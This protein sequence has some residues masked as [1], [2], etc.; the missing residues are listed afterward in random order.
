MLSTL[1]RPRWL[2]AALVVTAL[3]GLFIRLGLWQLERLDERRA[4][5]RVAVERLGSDPIDLFTALTEI[6]P[7]DLEYRRVTV[8]GRFAPEEEVLI[9]SQTHQGSAGFHIVSPLVDGSRG[10]LVNR[11]W[12]PLGMDRVPVTQA[13]PRAGEVTIEG[14]VHLTQTRPP[15]GPEEPPG[16]LEIFNRV[17]IDRIQ[18]QVT[19]E[20]GPVYVV[21]LGERGQGLPEPVE[22]PDFSQQG[23]H[24]AYAIQWFSFAAIGLVGFYFLA[25]RQGDQ[26]R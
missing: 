8:T 9:R 11:G 16:Y 15:I 3:A 25:R 19:V 22:P 23:P 24:L 7:S 5:N 10:V 26:P 1:R 13:A 6:A 21:A 18:Q 12:V 4:E 2:A 17:D 20:L 14:W